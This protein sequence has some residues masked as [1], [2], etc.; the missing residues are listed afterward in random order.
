MKRLRVDKM[1][2]SKTNNVTRIMNVGWNL[3]VVLPT[4]MYGGLSLLG[5]LTR[6]VSGYNDNPLRHDLWRAGHAHAGVYLAVGRHLLSQRPGCPTR[7]RPE[8]GGPGDGCRFPGWIA[9]VSPSHPECAG[10]RT[11][12]ASGDANGEQP[13]FPE[14]GFARHL[15]LPFMYQLLSAR[16]SVQTVTE[17]ELNLDGRGPTKKAAEIRL[18]VHLQAAPGSFPIADYQLQAVSPEIIQA[19]T[20]TAALLVLLGHKRTF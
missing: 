20:R 9:I 6:N 4:V 14:S 19:C 10:N 8:S 1:I 15:E 2:V 18:P 17:H 13:W 11:P 3:L 7:T 12:I 5:L 16:V